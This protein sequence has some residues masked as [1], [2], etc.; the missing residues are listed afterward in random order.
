MNQEVFSIIRPSGI[1]RRVF[2][3]SVS[4]TQWQIFV[5]TLFLPSCNLIS[6]KNVLITVIGVSRYYQQELSN[7]LPI[8][9]LPAQSQQYKHYNK[10]E[11]SFKV[12]IKETKKTS[13]DVVGFFIVNFVHCIC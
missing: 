1:F 11:N 2:N 13:N 10:V 9:H 3:I 4:S 8:G 7:P 12:N 5:I 6:Y